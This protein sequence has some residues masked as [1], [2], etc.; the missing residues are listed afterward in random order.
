MSYAPQESEVLVSLPLLGHDLL[1]SF[2]LA[3]L[4]EDDLR[5]S[6][7]LKDV[8]PD[9][10]KDRAEFLLD[11]LAVVLGQENEAVEH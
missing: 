2:F 11:V 3:L 10:K 9:L 6:E 4:R 1:L 5:G 7:V 8:K